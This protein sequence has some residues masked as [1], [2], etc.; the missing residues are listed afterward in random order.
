MTER[1]ERRTHKAVRWPDRRA[2]AFRSPWPKAAM[3]KCEDCG[4]Y[5]KDHGEPK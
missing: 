1:T 5:W 2:H 3:T 4:K